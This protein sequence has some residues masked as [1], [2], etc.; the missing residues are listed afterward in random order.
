MGVSMSKGFDHT[1]HG[2]KGSAR[3]TLLLFADVESRLTP[4]DNNRTLF[5][6]F[7][8]T[9]I[10][11]R[12]NKKDNQYIDT[13][14]TGT[15]IIQFW[16]IVESH[17]YTKMKTYLVT[18]H[19]EVDFM[20]L[21]GF[22][23]LANRGWILEKLISHN[24]VLVMFWKQDRKSLI[25]MNNGNLF[26]GSIHDWGEI[27]NVPKLDMP[28]ETAPLEDWKVYCM[29]DTVILSKMW[30]L[31]YNFI[32]EH[33]LGNFKLTK[34]SLAITAYRHRF[35]PVDISIHH[36]KPTLALER[37]SYK[38]GRFE[39]LQI[40]HF[41]DGPYYNLDINSMYGQIELNA[42]LPYEL[43]GQ[44]DHATFRQLNN[45][46]KKYC[47]LA[48][49][50]LITDAAA[51]PHKIDN[52]IVYG[53]GT[54]RTVLTTPELI[55]ALDRNWV[56]AVYR[57]AW[58]YQYPILSDYAA[59]FLALKDRYELEHNKPMR[60]VSKLYL[61]SLYGKFAQ[62][63]YDDKIIGECDPNEFKFI[64]TYHIETHERGT[65]SY[66]G[67]FI[68]ETTVSDFGTSTFISVAS[69]IT[70]Y[71]RLRIWELMKK[72]GVENV[73]HVAT[74]SLIVNAAGF[75]N[76]TDEIDP[77]TPGKLKLESTDPEI[78]IK[79]VNDRI[80]GFDV[81]IKGI[82]K[83]AEQLTENSYSITE[84]PRLLTLLKEGITD[85]YYTRQSVKILH[86]PR[87]YAS[88]GI[89]NPDLIKPVKNKA[90][91]RRGSMVFN[92][93][94]ADIQDQLDA[95]K[96]AR[97]IIPVDMLKLWDYKNGTFR[98]QRTLNG[99]LREFEYS[100]VNFTANYYHFGTI[101]ELMQEVEAQVKRDQ[102]TR[103]LKAQLT[104]LRRTGTMGPLDQG[105]AIYADPLQER[106]PF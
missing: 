50:D 40:G 77:H 64:S 10:F 87:F 67:G 34:A 104:A 20:P 81:K 38:G 65:I 41:T 33:D 35:M 106:I 1:L 17:T 44:I 5:T 14:Y 105:P 24:R 99:K 28:A 57:L 19:L 2:N 78:T 32:D 42:N 25:I 59:Y 103:K 58:Y 27:M 22:I 6:P 37:E 70:A 72:A 98:T 73:Y 60:Q 26:D 11:R 49:V 54:F 86:R 29:R 48:D 71:G 51:F 76:L 63:G 8:W 96:A 61:N 80:Q 4:Q 13:N 94:I 83:K 68:H 93:D 31:L 39:A 100:D 85:H 56:K 74:D 47:V 53:P 43:R 30:E 18:H 12:Y 16:D 82:P 97:R 36:D 89:V 90:N 21:K 84:W 102:E 46:L 3:P 62:H 92:P 7:L 75:Y 52:K 23:E 45:R 66:Y 91:R 101:Q 79:D 88:L 55:Y 69:H 9:M 95:L 15:D